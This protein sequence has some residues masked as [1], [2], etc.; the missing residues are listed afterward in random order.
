MRAALMTEFGKPPE[1]ADFTLEPPGPGEVH[2][3]I[4][5]AGV[6]HSDLSA[7]DGVFPMP[8]PFIMGHEGAGE[9]LAVGE[10]VTEVT[11]GDHVI[12]SWTPPCGNCPW[13]LNRQ[14]ELCLNVLAKSV[15]AP[16]HLKDDGTK[17][18]AFS[19]V[20]TFSEEAVVAREAVIPIPDDVPLDVASLIGC[21]VMTGVGA[22]INTAKVRPGSSVAVIGCGGVGISVIQGARIAGAAE[23]V[24]IDVALHKAEEAKR[25][26][27]THATTA[28]GLEDLKNEI[29]GGMG[30][31]DYAFEVV[32]HP[33]TI[34]QAYDLTRRGGTTC[35]VGVGRMDQ[36]VEFSAYELFFNAKT[37]MGS[38]YGSADVRSDFHRLLR[39][40]RQGKLDLEGMISRRFD[41]SELNDAFDVMKKGE[42]VR[43]VIEF[44]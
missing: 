30:G 7:I 23:I 3:R 41:L 28:D 24:A 26:G 27:A 29:T 18:A 17:I 31:F 13:C 21:G 5:A 34:R 8:L 35:I 39:L 4:G 36:P 25:F 42:V 44:K 9:V 6:C 19:G 33:A 38:M 12:I 1:I 11:P 10:G 32:G 37:L 15:F 2:L 40:W 22:A 16:H 43:S 14:P 20:G